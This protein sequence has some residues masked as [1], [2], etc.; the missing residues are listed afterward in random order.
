MGRPVGELLED[1]FG[2]DAPLVF[3][4]RRLLQLVLQLGDLGGGTYKE[5]PSPDPS[6]SA[7]QKIIWLKAEAKRNTAAK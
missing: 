3:P 2:A 7:Q 6:G 4:L 1:L 5:C